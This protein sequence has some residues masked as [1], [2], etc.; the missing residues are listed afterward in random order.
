M[1]HKPPIPENRK[2][3]IDLE[4]G[5]ELFNAVDRPDLSEVYAA[6]HLNVLKQY[7]LTTVTSSRMTWKENPGTYIFIARNLTTDEVVGGIRVQRYS[8]KFGLPVIDAIGEEDP[9]IRTMV[10]E[11]HADVGSGELCGLWNSPTVAKRGV[12]TALVM[13]A[14]AMSFEVGVKSLFGICAD[15]TMKLFTDHGYRIIRTLGENGVFEYP[16]PDYN[17][18]PLYLNTET[19]TTTRSDIREEMFAV[20]KNPEMIFTKDCITGRNTFRCNLKV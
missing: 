16:T 3:L 1:S 8:Q 13:V 7:G 4:I 15:Y 20:R 10:E 12:S 17:S 18:Y 14:M 19:L 9:N 6:G 5:L 11:H 2:I